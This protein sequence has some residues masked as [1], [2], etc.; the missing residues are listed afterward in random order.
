MADEAF[1]LIRSDPD[2]VIA[3]QQGRELA[4][5]LSLS[6][7]ELTLVAAAIS[8]LARNI[9]LYA[10]KGEVLIRLI[11]EGGRRG[12]LVVARDA[13]PGILDVEQA[14]QDGYSTGS[15]L[16]LGLPG[17]RRLMDEFEIVSEVGKG[18]VVT[19]KKWAR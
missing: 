15:G 19:V 18:T 14:L 8:E 1:V 7:S 4:A 2:I 9:L 5:Q 3:R 16:G 6:S 12:L 17:A 13:G 11:Q 10:Q